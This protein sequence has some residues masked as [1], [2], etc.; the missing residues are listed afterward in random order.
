MEI[1]EWKDGWHLWDLVAYLKEVGALGSDNFFRGQTDAEWGLLP[2]LYRRDV[3]IFSDKLSKP[4]L[5]LA[6]EE[7]MLDAFFN[8]AAM[9]LP[10]F[11]RGPLLDRIIAQ[12]YGVPTQL[13]DWTLDPFI[14][15]FFAV[16][17]GNPEKNCALFYI[18]S[19]RG[20]NNSARDIP[21]PWAGRVTWV[22]PPVI[23]ERVRAQKSAFTLQNFGDLE[24][25]TP[26]DQRVLKVSERGKGTHPDDEVGAFGKVII[27]AERRQ[28]ILFQLLELG[29]DSSLVYPGLQG[30]GQRIADLA[31]IQKYGG[32]QRY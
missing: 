4:Q 22:L 9:L 10:N 25:F 3:H 12:H 6:A 31:H 8:R 16:H 29:V 27:P 30:I 23:D 17:G 7:K 13:L 28:Q 20:L 32:S 21:L 1:S 2:G 5:Y 24:A 11:S 14:A 19:L 15:L 26:L 18:S